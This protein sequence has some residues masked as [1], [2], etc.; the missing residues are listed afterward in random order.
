MTIKCKGRN[1]LDYISHLQKARDGIEKKQDA[2][3][4]PVAPSA[5]G[6]EMT[7][8][9]RLEAEFV[10]LGTVIRDLKLMDSVQE[11]SYWDV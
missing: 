10:T 4:G 2:M 3:M 7:K 1:L 5:F 6:S 9:A 8:M 11:F